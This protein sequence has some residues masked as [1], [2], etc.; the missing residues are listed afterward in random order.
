MVSGSMHIGKRSQKCR[1][2]L[3]SEPST[4]MPTQP[5]PTL[6]AYFHGFTTSN[7]EAFM[8]FAR[9]SNGAFVCSRA[10]SNCRMFAV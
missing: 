4:C 5:C 1:H 9:P 7:V 8:I 2:I 3:F 6:N 10:V